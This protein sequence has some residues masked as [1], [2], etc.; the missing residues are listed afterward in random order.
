MRRALPT[1]TEAKTFAKQ[2]REDL[3]AH[4]TPISH[5]QALE[6]IAHRHGFRDWN[7]MHGALLDL[8][9][10]KWSVGG[11][12]TGAY[13]SQPFMATVLSVEP[14]R[15]GWHRLELDLDEAVDV[16]RFE[17]FSNFRKRIRIGIG[18]KGFSNERTS[19]GKPHLV[20]HP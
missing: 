4:G 15:P 19:D 10:K 9:A 14:L 7:A 11:R 16:V 20:L 17:G 8:P 3:A 2:L 5:S 13:L 1:R 6:K 12:V 18:P